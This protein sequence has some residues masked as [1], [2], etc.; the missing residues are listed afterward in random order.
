MWPFAAG[1]V[2][3]TLNSNHE[4]YSGGFGYFDMALPAMHQDASYF[5]LQNTN[6][7]FVGL[8]TAYIDHD[9]D[10]QQVAW[11]N[12]VIKESTAANGWQSQE[13]GAVLAPAAVL[14]GSTRKGPSSGRPFGICSTQRR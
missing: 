12:L 8:D 6:W 1:K 5:A 13:T 4:M 7:L 10:A 2:S 14:D 11:L 3:R 9:L